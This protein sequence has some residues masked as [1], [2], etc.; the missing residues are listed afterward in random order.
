MT[1]IKYHTETPFKLSFIN[2]ALMNLLHSMSKK[3]C[4][5]CCEYLS[6]YKNFTDKSILKT[7][8]IIN[9]IIFLKC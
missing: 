2:A 4:E 3:T 5:L 6:T 9:I 7:T 8:K 1:K